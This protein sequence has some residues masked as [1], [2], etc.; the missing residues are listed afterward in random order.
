MDSRQICTVLSCNENT[1]KYFSGVHS[2]DHLKHIHKK[3]KLLICNTDPSDRPGQHWVL[4]NFHCDTVEFFDSLGNHPKYYGDEFVKFM[5][6]F[7]NKCIYNARRIQPRGTSY[8]G[9][10]CILYAWWRCKQLDMYNTLL[11]LLQVNNI[12]L[13]VMYMLKKCR[14]VRSV[15]VVQK[16]NFY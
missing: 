12:E 2:V 14:T 7:A 4:F 1:A 9:H 16:C 3:P 6:R 15:T 13:K 5:S 11:H 8:C 10:Y